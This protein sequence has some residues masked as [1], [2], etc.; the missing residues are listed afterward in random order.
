MKKFLLP[1]LTCLILNFSLNA[2]SYESALAELRE[3]YVEA[4]A[5]SDTKAILEIYSKDAVVHHIDGSMLSGSREI[6][7]FYDDFFENSKA[8]IRFKN[9]S[10]DEL[11]RDLVFYHDEVYL[12]I[13]GEE[14]RDIEVVNVAEKKNG[15]WRVIKSYR[16]PM[17]KQ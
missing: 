11:A 6:G 5:N 10:E 15:E 17:P 4:L 8:T 14:P 13:E 7:D 12:Q 16:W 3:N 1:F 9:I 2:Q